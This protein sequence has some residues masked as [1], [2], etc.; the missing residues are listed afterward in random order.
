MSDTLSI[1]RISSYAAT[2]IIIRK[3][4][5]RLTSEDLAGSETGGWAWTRCDGQTVVVTP[6]GAFTVIGQSRS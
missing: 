3:P 5:E 1:R 4:R 2:Q 6:F